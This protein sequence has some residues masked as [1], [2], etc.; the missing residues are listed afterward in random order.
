MI[1][2]MNR[3][4]KIIKQKARIKSDKKKKGLPNIKNPSHRRPGQ[5]I[6]FPA[7]VAD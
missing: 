2:V 4:Y 1:G 6:L 5:R 7:D 3:P